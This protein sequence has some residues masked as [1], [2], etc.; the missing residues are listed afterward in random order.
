[1]ITEYLNTVFDDSRPW[2]EVPDT[3]ENITRHLEQYTLDPSFE[4]YGD[5]VNSSP[6]WIH[7]ED[8]SKYAGCT[9]IFGNFLTFSHAFRLVTNAPEL[10]ARLSDAIN[11]NK[12]TPEYQAAKQRMIERERESMERR[13]QLIQQHGNYIGYEPP[14]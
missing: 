4:H 10:I 9:M 2:L 7:P 8:A 11:K 14:Y 6:H 3:E 13:K 5:F 12:A 1:M